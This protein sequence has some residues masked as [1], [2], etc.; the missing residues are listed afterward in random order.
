MVYRAF[1]LLWLEGESLL[2]AP[3]LRRRELLES[4]TLPRGLELTPITQVASPM[5]RN[6]VRR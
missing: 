5:G 3:L 6:E 1:D 2:R 4:L